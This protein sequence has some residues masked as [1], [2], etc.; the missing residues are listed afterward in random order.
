MSATNDDT[1]VVLP[2]LSERTAT[3]TLTGNEI[4]QI[5][6]ALGLTK[7]HTNPTVSANASALFDRFIG[8][9]MDACEA[10]AARYGLDLAVENGAF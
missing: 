4:D 3:V 6:G 2:P 10:H 7:R 1:P 9:D 8:I 5:I